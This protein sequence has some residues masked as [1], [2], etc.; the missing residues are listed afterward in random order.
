MTSVDISDIANR[1]TSLSQDERSKIMS[2]EKSEVSSNEVNELK[3]I[4]QKL[5][6][7]NLVKLLTL[8][9][10]K[11][12]SKDKPKKRKSITK[13]DNGDNNDTGNDNNIKKRKSKKE[14][15]PNAP[16]RPPSAYLIFSVKKRKELA[17][18]G[19]E[20]KETMKEAGRLWKELDDASRK[21]YIDEANEKK[22]IYLEI[23]ENLLKTEKD[24][25]K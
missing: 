10:S 21:P 11:D 13:D 7:N 3:D 18:N 15:D 23:M 19:M 4:M 9:K 8:V 20:Y 5:T 6:T 14:K 16:K 24:L 22:K 2:K 17:E 12:K 1:I 25:K